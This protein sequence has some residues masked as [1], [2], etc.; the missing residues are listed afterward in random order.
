MLF[1]R[2]SLCSLIVIDNRSSVRIKRNTQHVYCWIKLASGCCFISE[3]PFQTYDF[4][5]ATLPCDIRFWQRGSVAFLFAVAIWMVHVLAY[6]RL[7][8]LFALDHVYLM[9]QYSRAIPLGHW[10][11]E[12]EG[13]RI[14]NKDRTISDAVS[15]RPLTFGGTG[16]RPG[17]SIWDLWWTEWHWDGFLFE[18]FGFL[19]SVSFHRDSPCSH[20]VWRI[21]Q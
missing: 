18:F 17:N 9:M 2:M 7:I 4:I 5:L 16:S 20:I 11:R 10:H 14:E 8:E 3:S 13:L 15:R 21:D 12:L 6:N 19:L 1:T